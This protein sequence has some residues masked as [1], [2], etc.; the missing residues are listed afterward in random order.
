MLEL[1]GGGSDASIQRE[2][3]EQL[4]RTGLSVAAAAVAL[5]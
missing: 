3:I 1:C 4:R 5:H 2:T